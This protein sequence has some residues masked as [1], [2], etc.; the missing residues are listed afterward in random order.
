LIRLEFARAGPGNL[1]GISASYADEMPDRQ[2]SAAWDLQ[3]DTFSVV[4]I[5]QWTWLRR[6][7]VA[8]VQPVIDYRG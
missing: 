8:L 1:F 7:C 2:G 3:T 6:R 4:E 5:S